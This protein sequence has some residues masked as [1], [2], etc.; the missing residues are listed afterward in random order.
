MS[1]VTL[2]N[3][4]GRI[5]GSVNK[6]LIEAA[7]VQ[8]AEQVYGD[9][10]MFWARTTDQGEVEVVQALK[11]VEVVEDEYREVAIRNVEKQR[12]NAKVGETILIPI[13]PI[14]PEEAAMR[15]VE[16]LASLQNVCIQQSPSA[17]S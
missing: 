3:W 8:A 9:E 7:Y 6:W 4:T 10:Y 12:P 16:T 14:V 2:L 5:E 17:R 15:G 1:A 11:I 13:D